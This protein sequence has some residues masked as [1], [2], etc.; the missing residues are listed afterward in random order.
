MFLPRRGCAAGITVL[1]L[2][3]LFPG[4]LTARTEISIQNRI[5]TAAFDPATLA[6]TLRRGDQPTIP[7]SAAQTNLGNVVGLESSAAK[8]RWSLPDR[9]VSVTLELEGN[10]L[11]AHVLAGEPGEFTFP[12]IPAT[13]SAK[14]WILPFFEGVYAPCAD[15]RWVSFLTNRGELN[16]TADLTIPFVGLDYGHATLTCIL[17]NPFNNQLEFQHSPDQGLQAR[18]THQFTRNHPV[19]EY[20]VVFEVGTNSL[21]EPA[22]LYR[23][24]LMQRGEFVSL[25]DKI[26][27][28]PEAGKLLGAAHA[29]LWGH[30]LLNQA[31]VT[32]WKK[33]AQELKSGGDSPSP[34]PAKRLWSLMKPEAKGFVTQVIQAEWPDRYMK[35]QIATD[36]DRLLRQR[37]LY[38][39][40]AWRGVAL[41]PQ[42]AALLQSDRSK[43]SHADLCR[44]NSHLLAA[45][46]P[47]Y[48]AKPE[49]WGN[50]TSPKMV[51]QLAAAGFDRF[52][53]GS[54]G[55]DAF[56]ERPETVVA[57][58][59]AGFLIGPYDSYN[60]I[61]R[62]NEPD[63]WE[64]SQF[65]AALYETGAIVNADGTKR[66]GFKQKGFKLS[67]DAARPY[68]E[69]RVSG[70]MAIFPANSWFI[71]CDGFG[72]YFDDY[73]DKHPATQQ[74]DMQSRIA[75]MSWIR[76]TF[77]AV[78][79]TEGCSAGVAGAVHFAHGVMTPV[80]GWGDP[81]LSNKQS[82][83]YLG[84][85]YPPEE[86]QVFFKPVPLKEEYRY[87]Y[88]EPRFRLPLFQTVFHD[89]VIATHHWSFA[90]LK[91][92]DQARTM[93]LL[94][95]LYQVPPLYHLNVPEFQK[96]KAQ[97]KRHYEFFSPLHR[98]T[99]LL[100][101]TGFQ[102][103]T[104]DGT[105]QR[106]AFGDSIEMV[107]NFGPGDFRY[108]STALSK[109]TILVTR[110]G[111]GKTQ[112]YSPQ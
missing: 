55:W 88:F 85:Y 50:G 106:T 102:W 29:Y 18:L 36:L 93:E 54:D 75:R 112:V 32:D 43:L 4:R 63:T 2:L 109:D 73:S 7:V 95:L 81:D 89:S 67:P 19:K 42:C 84:S 72:E 25:K 16:T 91:T 69:K 14:G 47:N 48:L 40:P 105:V 107:A 82:K 24:W 108:G 70:L 31:D 8:A 6:V 96:R 28:T 99:A 1:A 20:G 92:K 51:Q 71:D 30:E 76:D 80:I 77:G 10:R 3:L 57:A 65:D 26:H 39:E 44:L 21:V 98:E 12:V 15:V 78:I 104:P 5:Y 9:K 62:P 46:F 68:V 22:R 66:R 38:D 53:L 33:L 23:Q 60:G 86:P 110:R 100:P 45:A 79:G 111:S 27:K 56:L 37:D 11:L 83:Y 61:H 58:K 52:W 74:S 59:Q 34:S 35:S 90:S 13:A 101:M 103:L 17:T 97:M 87:I 94:E 41:D 64:T 49:T